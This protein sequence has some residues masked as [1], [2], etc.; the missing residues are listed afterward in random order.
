[1]FPV[2]LEAEE[3]D[4][5]FLGLG[6]VEDPQDRCDL[7]EG[8]HDTEFNGLSAMLPKVRSALGMG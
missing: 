6:F 1:V 2:D 7:S 3:V 4:L 5:E 8:G